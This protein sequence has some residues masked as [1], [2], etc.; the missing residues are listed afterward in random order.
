M[1]CTLHHTPVA[2]ATRYWGSTPADLARLETFVRNAVS[3]SP[4]VLVAVR[5]EQDSTDALSFL[6]SLNLPQ[7]EAFGV[8]PWYG[9]T[10]AINAL[11][12]KAY[13]A[14]YS[15]VLIA[16]VEFPPQAA[17]VLYLQHFAGRRSILAAGSVL[18]GHDYSPGVEPLLASGTTVPWHT[19]DLINL[20]PV[21]KAGI[22]M[23]ADAPFDPAMAG[24]EEVVMLAYY[25]ANYNLRSILVPVPGINGWLNTTGWSNERLQ[26]HEQ[27]LR[28]KA[29][30]AQA[31]LAFM[32]LTPSWVHHLEAATFTGCQLK[33]A[34]LP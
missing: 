16:S 9:F 14:G 7:V 31:Q 15:Q 24:I 27:K 13:R 8:M 21:V 18:P 3:A 20:D 12:Y 23:A 1:K 10:P 6:E 32:G 17:Q 30:R 2:I 34:P 33:L 19:F 28:M 29:A 22:P 5:I 4:K 11:F 26:T 25:E